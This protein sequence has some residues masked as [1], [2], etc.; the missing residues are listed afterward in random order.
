MTLYRYK[1]I[2]RIKVIFYKKH[3]HKHTLH[4]FHSTFHYLSVFTIIIR[5]PATPTI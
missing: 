1:Y 5:H 3:T 2:E 4:S